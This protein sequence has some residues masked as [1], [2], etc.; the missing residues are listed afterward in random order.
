MQGDSGYGSWDGLDLV[1]SNSGW[2]CQSDRY[3]N[4][5]QSGYLPPAPLCG[6]QLNRLTS[7]S[8]VIKSDPQASSPSAMRE[9]TPMTTC[10]W[11]LPSIPVGSKVRTRYAMQ[12]AAVCECS[13]LVQCVAFASC[14]AEVC[15]MQL[16]VVRYAGGCVPRHSAWC[17]QQYVVAPH[18]SAHDHHWLCCGLMPP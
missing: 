13:L 14:V 3:L 16:Q 5:G 18:T 12:T 4:I 1:N 11:E 10:A 15:R 2:Q 8:G 9:Y 17:C 6:P 7:L